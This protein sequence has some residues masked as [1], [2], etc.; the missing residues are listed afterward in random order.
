MGPV[1]PPPD[2]RIQDARRSYE[3]TVF[4]GEP[5][6]LAPA[7]RGLDAVEA[8]LALARGQLRHARFL[9]E[10][11]EDPDELAL[12]ERA[13]RLHESLGDLRGQAEALFWVGCCLQ[14]VRRDNDRATPVLERSAALAA[15]IGD[16]LTRSYA[17]R[18]LGIA[19]HAAGRRDAARSLLEE[20]VSLRRELG[21]AAGVAANLV[22]LAY[23]AAEEGRPGDVRAILTEA[24]EL[25]DS[26]DAAGITRQVEEAWAQLLS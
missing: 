4:G 19:E 25:A 20:S 24:R 8:D 14:V 5:G 23:L 13:V 18:H 21:F 12:F 7:E 10:R 11:A 22:G 6:L 26:A 15:Q 3:R 16:T 1:E 17:L 2:N 9:A